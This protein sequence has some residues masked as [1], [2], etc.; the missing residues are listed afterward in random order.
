MRPDDIG[1]V[2]VSN[3]NHLLCG[4]R[5]FG[6][7]LSKRLTSGF[8]INPLSRI[9]EH[10][11]IKHILDAEC[12]KFLLLGFLSAIRD[13]PYLVMSTSVIESVFRRR[14]K[15]HIGFI[16]DIRRDLTQLSEHCCIHIW[17]GR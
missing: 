5:K 6:N 15:T 2:V 14:A 4:C 1:A 9:A 3:M 13:E 17:T 8:G 7:C 12:F 16:N 11:D 10:S